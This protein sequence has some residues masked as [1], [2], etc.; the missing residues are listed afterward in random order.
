MLAQIDKNMQL[1]TIMILN[2]IFVFYNSFYKVAFVN[3]DK[4][5]LEKAN[6]DW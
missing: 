2:A 6:I 3:H 5:N 1:H 4:M